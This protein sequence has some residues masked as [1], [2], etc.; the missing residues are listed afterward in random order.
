LGTTLGAT[1]KLS[2]SRSKD[3]AGISN[4]NILRD[5]KPLRHIVLVQETYIPEMPSHRYL[6][7]RLFHQDGVQSQHVFS[8]HHLA[9]VR[10]AP[11]RLSIQPA[12]HR[13]RVGAI[14]MT[15]LSQFEFPFMRWIWSYRRVLSTTAQGAVPLVNFNV[16]TAQREMKLTQKLTEKLDNCGFTNVFSPFRGTIGQRNG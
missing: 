3:E 13:K 14:R 8:S 2:S 4:A 12:W 11:S 7:H 5:R 9:Q 10:G 15:L 1:T 16:I 6:P